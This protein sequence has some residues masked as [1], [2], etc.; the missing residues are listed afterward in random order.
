MF[1]AGDQGGGEATGSSLGSGNFMFKI[2]RIYCEVKAWNMH[3]R[4]EC[5]NFFIS[6]NRST[7]Q[8]SG[9]ILDI[10]IQ[11][12]GACQGMHVKVF[13]FKKIPGGPNINI[14]L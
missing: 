7:N 1:P 13:I 2:P 14:V 6:Q 9:M 10:Q 8:R 12:F 11:I 3:T 5:G 4:V